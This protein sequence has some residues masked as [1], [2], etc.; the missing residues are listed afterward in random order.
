MKS[1]RYLLILII[2]G[3]VKCDDKYPSDPEKPEEK[4]VT[5]RENVENSGDQCDN[6]ETNET[7]HSNETDKYGPSSN[8]PQPQPL[9]VPRPLT[10]PIPPP[11]QPQSYQPGYQPIPIQQIQPQ[12][13]TIPLQPQQLH[14]SHPGYQQYHP[15]IQPHPGTITQYGPYQPTPSQPILL[16]LPQA[17]QPHYDP[18]QP[19]TVPQT[20]QLEQYLGYQPPPQY[21]PVQQYI[22]PQPYYQTQPQPY[23]PVPQYQPTQPQHL[24]IPTPIQPT[25]Q[26]GTGYYGPQH[27]PHPPIHQPYG[28]IPQ[29]I[30]IPIQ[31]QITQPLTIPIKQPQQLHGPQ[32]P[33]YIP[34]QQIHIQQPYQPIQPQPRYPHPQHPIPIHQPYGPYQAIHTDKPIQPQVPVPQPS[35]PIHQPPP[36]QLRPCYTQS[37]STTQQQSRDQQPPDQQP[38]QQQ[39]SQAR[40]KGRRRYEVPP[41]FRNREPQ[42]QADESKEHDESSTPET[43][44]SDETKPTKEPT[45]TQEDTEEP[46][47]IEPIHTSEPE[48][49]EPETIPVEVGSDEE[50][51]PTEPPSGPGDGDQPPDKPEEEAGEGGDEEE[52]EEEEGKKPDQRVKICEVIRFFKKNEEGVLVEMS[53]GDYEITGYNTYTTK[54]TL[55]DKLEKI[56]CDGETVY[57]Y[58]EGK[59]YCNYLT[60]NRI[61][62]SFIVRNKSGFIL[63]RFSEGIWKTSSRSIPN[64]VKIYKYDS[65]GNLVEISPEECTIDLTTGGSLKYKFLK[66]VKCTKIEIKTIKAWEKKD[67]SEYP[68]GFIITTGNYMKLNFKRFTKVLVKKSEPFEHYYTE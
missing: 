46:T 11:T 5:I 37:G 43:T 44:Q 48:Q 23:Y 16:P 64:F 55:Y 29:P 49:L 62:N 14:G 4:I 35:Q 57:E 34:P 59:E 9:S 31:P 33:Q 63:C 58:K 61:K 20:Y 42:I 21:Q 32:P 56:D 53:W 27:Q 60:Y 13:L 12:P 6:F 3:Y 67:E 24:A 54:Y 2:I 40:G 10:I 18:Y 17:Y 36:Q 30:P 41:R 28:P 52:E 45:Q 15:Q 38:Q 22:P 26:P 66:E 50:E 39:Q 7:T 19:L 51:E 65:E 47:Q 1:Y 8:E 68:I 25:P